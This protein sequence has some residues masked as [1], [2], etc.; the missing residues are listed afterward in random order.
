MSKHVSVK[1]DNRTEKW[2]DFPYIMDSKQLCSE[3]DRE[4][5]SDAL[6]VK[7]DLT[8]LSEDKFGTLGFYATYNDKLKKI[9]IIMDPSNPKEFTHR[10]TYLS[11]VVFVS[12]ELT[13]SPSDL[14]AVDP[15]D[16]HTIVLIKGSNNEGYLTP[17]ISTSQRVPGIYFI[18]LPGDETV[19]LKVTN[20]LMGE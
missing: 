5:N 19:C 16:L 14:L 12:T 15:N 11:K 6:G 9:E 17:Y 13:S 7:V 2:G 1:K 3:L 20:F 4:W 18:R 8:T 10:L